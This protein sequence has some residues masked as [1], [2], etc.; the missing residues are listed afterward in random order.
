[1]EI[2]GLLTQILSAVVIAMTI[3]FIGRLPDESARAYWNEMKS[4]HG[5]FRVGAMALVLPPCGGILAFSVILA[6]VP[7][8]TQD[9]SVHRDMGI[10]LLTI[11]WFA[12]LS[13]GLSLISLA[14]WKRRP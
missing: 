6:F 1:M 10:I 3:W 14:K 4:H 8:A 7:T 13:I 2:L 9:F 12:L 5:K 11:N